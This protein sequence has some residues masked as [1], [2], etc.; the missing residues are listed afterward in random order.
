VPNRAV[1]LELC[2]VKAS[3]IS[4]CHFLWFDVPRGIRSN[5][6]HEDV[7]SSHSHAPAHRPGHRRRGSWSEDQSLLFCA[8]RLHRGRGRAIAQARSS[9]LVQAYSFTSASLT[10]ALIEAHRRGVEVLA[11]LDRSQRAENYSGADPLKNAGIKTLID[12]KHAIAHNKIMVI[13]GRRV[14]TGGFNSTKA[15]EQ[16]NAENLLVIDNDPELMAKYIANWKN[17]KRHS[18]PFQRL[19]KPIP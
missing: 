7:A 5:R 1:D 8:R 3:C 14:I 15:A 11:I 10:K 12:D 16:N 4:P 13:D 6:A 2:E 9:I 18:V 19:T 17:H